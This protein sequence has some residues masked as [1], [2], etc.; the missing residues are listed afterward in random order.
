MEVRTAA[1][2]AAVV[3]ARESPCVCTKIC[4]LHMPFGLVYAWAVLFLLMMAVLLSHFE[5]SIAGGDD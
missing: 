5:G 2:R 1:D 4:L 3:M